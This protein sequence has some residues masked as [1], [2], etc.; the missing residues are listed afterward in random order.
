MLDYCVGISS[1]FFLPDGSTIYDD[2]GTDLLD[3]AGIRWRRLSSTDLSQEEN[4]DELN[5]ILVLRQPVTGKEL[6]LMPNCRHIARW[7]AGLDRIDVEECT[8]RGVVVTSTPEGGR[9]P[10]ASAALALLLSLAHQIPQ[11]DRIVR[12]GRWAQRN[13]VM[14][15]GLAQMTIGIFGLGTIGSEFVRLVKPFGASVIAGQDRTDTDLAAE[16]GVELAD[17]DSLLA[18]ADAVIIMCP[19]THETRHLIDESALAL[20]KP[21]AFLVNVARG[22]IV[23]ESALTDALRDGRIRGAGLDVFE[24]E[25]LPESSPLLGFDNVIL[26]PHSLAWGEEIVAGNRLQ[27]LEDIEA[28]AVGKLPGAPVNKAV[29]R[30]DFW[31]RREDI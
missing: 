7:G 22:E 12:E 29:L 11:R 19:L 1:E 3:A 25:P 28:V 13:E 8:R 31:G 30:D 20:M 15:V 27:A 18:R 9:R 24:T 26:A 6:D 10:V 16:L 4:L 21:S 23:D 14:G 5:S 2:I 17:R